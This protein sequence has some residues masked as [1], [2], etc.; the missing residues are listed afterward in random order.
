M[1]SRVPNLPKFLGE[2]ND[3][4]EDAYDFLDQCK[5]LFLAHLLPEDRWI[6]VLLPALTSSDRQWAEANLSNTPW[7]EADKCFLDHCESPLIKDQLFAN[8]MCM[9]ESKRNRTT[10]WWQVYQPDAEDRT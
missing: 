2:K 10:V 8:F 4:I 5:S 6:P 3:A 7:H 1:Q 9:Y